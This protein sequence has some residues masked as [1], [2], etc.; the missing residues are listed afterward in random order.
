MCWGGGGG[1]RE[2]KKPRLINSRYPSQTHNWPPSTTTWILSLL[3]T[4]IYIH[5]NLHDY[6]K[7]WGEFEL[8]HY[9]MDGWNLNAHWKRLFSVYY[10]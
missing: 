2:S 4:K 6:Y 8:S 3:C 5:G 9:Q 1:R 7:D 10:Q